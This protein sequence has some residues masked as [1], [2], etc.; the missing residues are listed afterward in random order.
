MASILIAFGD[1]LASAAGLLY[2]SLYLGIALAY[3]IQQKE[4]WLGQNEEDA[5]HLRHALHELWSLSNNDGRLEHK[6][7]KLR[8]GVQ[9]HYLTPRGTETA[10]AAQTLVVFVHGFPDSAHLFT[11]QLHSPLATKAKLVALDF[12]G[13]GG[14][15]S[16]ASYGPD[17]VL[18]TVAEAIVQ[19]KKQYLEGRSTRCILVGHDWGGVVG[20]RL[21]AETE[22][23]I[24]EL[25]TLNSLW[26]EYAEEVLKSHLSRGQR[27]LSR[28]RM[29][30]ARDELG[31]VF[32]QLQKSGYTYMLSL[33]FPIAKWMP[34]VT[35][36]LLKYAQGLEYKQSPS[37]APDILATRLAMAYGP[38]SLESA[39]SNAN[40]PHYGPS[41]LDRSNSNPPGD[42]DA[43]VRLY[44]DGLLREKW[45][46]SYNGHDISGK[47][48]DDRA[49]GFRCPVHII[50]GLGDVA[51][52]PR[53][54][55]DGIEKYFRDDARDGK[56][57]IRLPGCGHWS[58]LE[59]EGIKALDGVLVELIR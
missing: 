27:L 42:W 43:R 34:R 6:F 54:V 4:T 37:Q 39:L 59:E 33:P 20:F 18:N 35:A 7:L 19:L 12:P 14:S 2:G 23:L 10:Q 40:S 28:W 15:D 51:L 31:P 50:F 8:N 58:I 32:S 53:V 41:V 57:I 13:C 55:L 49:K 38:S 5:A 29:S 36:S 44:A 24:D 26:P 11:R 3:S 22:G 9:L 21:A 52:D 17:E 1:L 56:R 45:T 48:G 47:H 16:L 46:P 30:E 25:V